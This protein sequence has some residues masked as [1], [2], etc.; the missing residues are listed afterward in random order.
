MK[1][2]PEHYTIRQL[3]ELKKSNL[4]TVNPEYQRGAVWT[5]PQKK[6][7]IDSVL[8]GYPL[9]LIYL[10][11][12]RKQVANITAEHFEVIDGQQRSNALYEFH[13]GAFKL[14]DPVKD[15]AVARFPNFIKRAPCPW[16]GLD[17]HGLPKEL[18]ATFLDTQLSIVLISSA[19]QNE[20]RDLFIRLQAGMPLTAQEKR[21]AWPGDFTDFV[22]RV[23]GKPEIARY[24]GHEFFTKLMGAKSGDSRGK[25]RQFC[26][27]ILMLYLTRKRLQG[28]AVCDT[29]AEAIDDFYYQNIDFDTRSPEAERFLKILDK[30]TELLTPK[31]RKKVLGHEA[32]HL[33]LLLDDLWDDYTRSWETKLPVAFD[34]FRQELAVAVSKRYDAAPPEYWLRYGQWTRV[35]SD[36]KDTIQRRH[37]FFAQKMFEYLKPIAKDPQRLYGPVEREVIYYRDRKLCGGCEGEVSWPEAEIHHLDGHASGGKTDLANGVLVHQAC[38]PKGA[39]AEAEFAKKWRA[40]HAPSPET[41]NPA[42]ASP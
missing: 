32:M 17:F 25:F 16:G 9:P 29:N 6:R 10:H 18:Q 4:L 27:Q 11:H 13:E 35:N 28:A 39:Q 41:S 33:V 7:L 36:R 22:L 37:T 19:D 21:D 31:K 12:V 2:D 8:R 30:L 1:I 38:H 40:K 5:Q 26:A 15:D 3:I 14:F 42:P 23:G 20:P 34:L 24:P